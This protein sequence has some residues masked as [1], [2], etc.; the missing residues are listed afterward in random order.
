MT[1]GS[2]QGHQGPEV[3]TSV[4]PQYCQVSHRNGFCQEEKWWP[5]PAGLH[6]LC[7]KSVVKNV[8]NFIF[9]VE[10]NGPLSV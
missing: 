10:V 9:K 5:N 6:N 2:Q 7:T 4:E 3:T 1:N 8:S